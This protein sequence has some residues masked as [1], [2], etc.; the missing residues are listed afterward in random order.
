MPISAIAGSASVARR[1]D[2]VE[3][4]G[5]RFAPVPILKALQEAAASDEAARARLTQY[6]EDVETSWSL[7]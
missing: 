7:V 5:A 1:A 4:P 3:S 2:M 6:D